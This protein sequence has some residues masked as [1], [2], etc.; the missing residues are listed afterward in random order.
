MQYTYS[1]HRLCV[2]PA[3]PWNPATQHNVHH[4]EFTWFNK[5]A[6]RVWLLW[7]SHSLPSCQPLPHWAKACEGTTEWTV[8][9]LWRSDNNPLDPTPTNLNSSSPSAFSL[10]LPLS[11]Y[12][13]YYLR[14]GEIWRTFP[15]RR[16]LHISTISYVTTGLAHLLFPR[17]FL[18]RA[19]V[20]KGLTNTDEKAAFSFIPFPLRHLCLSSEK[21][22]GK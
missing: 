8:T 22:G 3:C 6:E 14:V 12:F 18:W 10:S 21:K 1:Q 13:F 20:R 9:A 16:L 17:L 7:L 5:S 15:S 2:S 4:L 19:C 11:L